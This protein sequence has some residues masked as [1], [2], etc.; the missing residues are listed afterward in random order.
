MA[1]TTVRLSSEERRLVLSNCFIASAF[2][3]VVASYNYMLD[4]MLEG[5]NVSDTES[6]LL[7]QLPNIAA[8]LV[9]FLG[10]SLGDRFGDR[11]M[12]I[13]VSVLYI[14]G[15]AMV[16]AAPVYSVACLG[17]VLE[18][19]AASAG[20]VIS[21]GLLSARITEPRNRASAFSIFGIVS[22]AIYLVVPLLAGVMV[23]NLSWRYVAVL[24]VLAGIL[25]LWSTL[26]LIPADRT[27]R[28]ADEML[29]P[30]IAGFVLAAF[31][32]WINAITTSG[33]TSSTSLMYLG[34]VVV[35]LLWLV[36]L[37]RRPV[38]RSLSLAALKHGGMLI[39]LAVVVL[40]PFANLWFYGTMG[41]QY[42]FGLTVLQTA[43]AMIPAQLAGV[44]AGMVIRKV[45]Q[46]KGVRLT[47][48]G[49]LL[50]FA[51]S[52]LPLLF[53]KP[54]SPLWVPVLTFALYG[55]G[56]TCAGIPITN[57]VMNT[58]ARGEEGS[59]AAFRSAS[60][61][62][63]NSLGVVFTTGL[64]VTVA[65]SSL[66]TQLN[67]QGTNDNQSKQIIEGLVNGATSEEV[68]SQYS[69]PVQQVQV[70][71]SDLAN[72]LISSFHVVSVVG[73]LIALICAGLFLYAL[74]E[75]AES[76]PEAARAAS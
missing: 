45:L 68:A 51:V 14:A 22:P 35:G 16:A 15:T 36:W 26:R 24:W 70:L 13:Y 37:F 28:G 62:V 2:T 60:N 66:L 69:V 1:E 9:V 31:V 44:A 43:M 8:L 55:F 42:V 54:N 65:T 73:A 48:T 11:K 67:D 74:R 39:L 25:M 47:G 18:S 27:T 59:A 75:Q 29:S 3:I 56:I 49:A 76:G 33:L 32:Q 71:D 38:K 58:A 7:R 34:V 6:S 46:K 72:A 20:A 64:L 52:M 4:P 17:L 5:L 53:I 30:I 57:A 40:V 23:D 41:F 19:V 63:G 21:L 10:G 12:L 50:T 61:K